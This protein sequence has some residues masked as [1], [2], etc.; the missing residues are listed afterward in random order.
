MKELTPCIVK[1]LLNS[2]EIK[3]ICIGLSIVELCLAG[4]ISWLVSLSVSQHK[5]LLTRKFF[6]FYRNF[7][8][9]F[10]IGL[11]SEDIFGF[12]LHN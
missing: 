9:G 11:N 10:E 6:K 12:G 4:G 1:M 2:E 7:L 5:I 3:P 8:E